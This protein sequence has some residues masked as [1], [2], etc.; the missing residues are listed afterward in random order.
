ML[1]SA[2]RG[3]SFLRGDSR[4]RLFVLLAMVGVLLPIT[5]GNVASLLVAR[6]SAREREIAVRSAMGA[7]R[8][9]VIRQLLVETCCCRCVGGALGLLAAAWGRDLLLSMFSGGAAIIDLDTSFDWRVL[10]FARLGHDALRSC[11]RR[12]AGHSQHARLA[13]RRDQGAVAPGRPCRR[14]PRRVDRQDARRP[15][16]SRSA[17]CCWSL[18]ACSCAA[19][20]R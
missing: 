11:G 7:G 16:R 8:W 6:A 15:A 20:R 9:R 14:P 12:A 13:K 19:C 10:L 2:G 18:P 17:C 3:V 4:S 5:C 1:S